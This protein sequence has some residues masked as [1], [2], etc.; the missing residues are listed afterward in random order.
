MSLS[1]DFLAPETTAYTSLTDFVGRLKDVVTALEQH[2]GPTLVDR[3]GIRFIDRVSGPAK[4]LEQWQYKVTGAGRIWY[5]TDD[6]LHIVFITK[7]RT[8][9]PGETDE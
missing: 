5:C 7:A 9:H 1:P 4:V 3:L 2:I 6:A 8:G